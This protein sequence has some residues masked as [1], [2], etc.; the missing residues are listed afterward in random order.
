[1]QYGFVVYTE[2]QLQTKHVMCNKN[3]KSA[4]NPQG[5]FV[6]PCLPTSSGLS[7]VKMNQSTAILY[8]HTDCQ[9]VCNSNS[10]QLHKFL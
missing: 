4:S 9:W 6:G 8:L 1:M 7:I 2:P 5:D 3:F 10:S